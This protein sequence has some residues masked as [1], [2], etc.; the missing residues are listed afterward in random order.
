[1]IFI[2][3]SRVSVPKLSVS[4]NHD[5]AIW[6]K[7]INHKFLVHF[8]LRDMFYSNIIKNRR[9]NFFYASYPSSAFGHCLYSVCPSLFSDLWFCFM[10]ISRMFFPKLSIP[11]IVFSKKRFDMRL[12][13]PCISPHPMPLSVFPNLVSDFGNSQPA[14]TGTQ[15][16]SF[17]RTITNLTKTA[18]LMFSF[19]C[20]A[21]EAEITHLAP[22][23][24]NKVFSVT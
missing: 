7:L 9:Q 13:K 5:I 20:S 16:A 2:I 15:N 18:C 12:H 10:S 21:I 22:S 17:L 24:G 1:M 8:F 14:P 11:R 19:R 6:K 23:G 4:L 3:E